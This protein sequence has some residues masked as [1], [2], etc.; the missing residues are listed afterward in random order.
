MYSQLV[1][2]IDSKSL[3]NWSNN[4]YRVPGITA[5]G[6]DEFKALPHV[7]Q[8][9]KDEPYYSCLMQPYYE[10]PAV[11][12]GPPVNASNKKPLSGI[13]LLEL[14]RAIAA[15]TIGRVCAALGATVIRVSS[16]VN[17]ELPI[18]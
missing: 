15:E 6:E 16:S 9:I 17:K 13:K 5:Y 10:Q 4:V 8:S 1:E 12:W 7:R 3:D 2:R 18:T 11:S 14:A